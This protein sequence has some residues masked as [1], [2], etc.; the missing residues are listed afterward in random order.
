MAFNTA[1]QVRFFIN[2]KPRYSMETHYGD[3]TASAFQVSGAPLVSGATSLGGRAP[4]ALVPIGNAW[5]AT[6]VTFDY[7]QGLVT[8]SGVI[9]AESAFQIVYTYGTFSDAEIDFVTAN[10]G[11]LYSMRL[12]LVDNLMG[13]AW[14][15]MRWASVGGAH[16]DDSMAMANLL[17]MREAI[18][19]EMTTE[20]GGQMVYDSWSKAQEDF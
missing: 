7:N 15:R 4:S 14:K 16:F 11:D 17:R 2:D 20:Q 13:D 9:S 10:F 8:F 6:G 12:A 19:A 5:S 1:E 18:R 3:G